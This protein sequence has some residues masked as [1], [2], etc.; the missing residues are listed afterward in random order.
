MSDT[1]LLVRAVLSEH[2]A[3]EAFEDVMTVFRSSNR[4]KLT[5]KD[6]RHLRAMHRNGDT[7]SEIADFYSLN[8]ATVSRIV[9]GEYF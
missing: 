3:E 5:D 4:K 8:P 9:R 1:G 6:V 7:Q 2:G